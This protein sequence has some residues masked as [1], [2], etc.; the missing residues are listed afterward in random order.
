MRRI[1]TGHDKNG[2]SIFV[3]DGE[4]SRIATLDEFPG[5]RLLDEIWATDETPTIPVDRIEGKPSFAS[6]DTVPSGSWTGKSFHT[7]RR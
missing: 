4:T 6:Y 7:D 5:I 1:V 2:K 3:S